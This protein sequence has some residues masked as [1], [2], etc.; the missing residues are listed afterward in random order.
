MAAALLLCLTWQL[1]C[2]HS[3]V[4]RLVLRRLRPDL[5]SVVTD[6]STE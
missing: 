1:P 5:T 2:R 4:V 3:L 6:R